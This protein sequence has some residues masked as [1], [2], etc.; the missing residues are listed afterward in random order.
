MEDLPP[1]RP[2]IEHAR[3]SKSGCGLACLAEGSAAGRH[4]DLYRSSW[5]GMSPELPNA[6]GF[7]AYVPGRLV[8]TE[9]DVNRVAQ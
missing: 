4:P 7:S 8:V 3:I 5:N 9:A 1:G 6:R 2:Q